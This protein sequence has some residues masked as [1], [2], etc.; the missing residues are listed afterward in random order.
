MNINQIM[1]TAELARLVAEHYIAAR[2]EGPYTLYNYTEKATFDRV[3]TP[4]T[5][6]CRGLIVDGAGEIVA[7]PFDKFFNLDEAEETR[8]AALETR[9]GPIEITEKLDG[10]MVAVW[11]HDGSWHTSTRGSFNST[12]AQAAAWWLAARPRR[13]T[14]ILQ[15]FTLLCEWCAPDN[16]VVLKYDTADLVLIG[17]R[18]TSTGIDLHHE[19]L[20][21]IANLAGLRQAPMTTESL[22]YLAEQRGARVGM[23]GWVA[24]WPDGFRVKIKTEDYLR[25]H[26]L[27]SNFNP[28]RVRDVLAGIDGDW[29]TYLAALPEEFRAEAE[30]MAAVMD[31]AAAA[32]VAAL[33]ATFERLRP[34]VTESRKAYA[35]AVLQEPADDRPYLFSLIDSKPIAAKVLAALDLDSLFA[36]SG[37]LG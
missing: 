24:R 8:I 11:Y 32:R 22:S 19:Q 3:W 25:L 12:Q 28:S 21:H 35:M 34:L 6:Q 10:S 20:C 4:E 1:D 17:A 37:A 7:W 2:N 31:D 18:L 15:E 36:P 30:R 26:R 13:F 23:E 14:D 33:L 5:R 16:R 27:V 29:A 9:Q